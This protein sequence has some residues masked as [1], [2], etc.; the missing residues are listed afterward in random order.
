MNYLK[1][2]YKWIRNDINYLIISIVAIMFVTYTRT[3]IPLFYQ[4][5]IDKILADLKPETK[6][7]AILDHESSLPA[8]FKD[9]IN[10]GDS[11]LQKLLFLVILLLILQVIR[12]VFMF[13][14]GRSNA[15]FSESIAY[16]MRVKLYDHIQ[17]LSYSYHTH[18]ETGDLI[19]RSTSDIDT[20]RRFVGMQL[21]EVFRI[22]FLFTFTLIQMLRIHVAMTF[23]S[24]IVVPF[25]FTF[26]YIFFKRIQS[27][28]TE[29][30]E[31][32]GKMS[33]ALQENLTGIR[34]V[35]A[36]ANEK[37]EINKF[38]SLSRK[39][40]DNIQR[41]INSMAVY[42][43]SSDL[44]I[45]FQII[46][47]IVAG[48]YFT[49]NGML[50]LGNFVA[51]ISYITFI[52]WPIRQLGR[53]IVDFGKSS[54]SLNRIEE[55]LSEEDEYEHEA[56]NMKTPDIRGKVEFRNVS[57]QFD[58]ANEPTLKN[59]S[60]KINQGETIAVI[61]KTG[62][63]KSTLA[64]LL[65]RLYDYTSGSIKIDGT[66]L[67]EIDKKWARN[68]IGI[69]LQEPFLFSRSI[70]ENI[71]ILSDK[72]KM[73]EEE[74]YQAA[75]IASVHNDI[76]D[77]EEGYKTLV[78]ERGVTLS[79]GQKQRVA[80]ARML[81]KNIPILIFD[82][83]LSAVD[84]E[85]DLS[86]RNALKQR[87]DDLTKIIITHRIS[88]AMEADRIIV[89]EDGEI[90]EMGSHDELV[91]NSRIYKKIWEIQGSVQGDFNQ[92]FSKEEGED[93]DAK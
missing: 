37:H 50:S 1:S 29:T 92:S 28:F 93:N 46:T 62:S 69:I 59:V 2:I 63:G 89:L 3:F 38:D 17:N 74:I 12:A 58:D 76:L 60:F 57:F 52:L 9:F 13:I 80:I 85:T 66:E 25:I 88:T 15:V 18:A 26:A 4:Y 90:A 61:G 68:H 36:F 65:V 35:K 72:D 49:I 22:L 71:G 53:V 23:I 54:V 16:K 82:D 39:Y 27:V 34:V 14:R 91:N 32:E 86:I 8:L 6:A 75:Q 64:H 55:V 31:S 43:S 10:I 45:F 78:G 7:D 20:V 42:W 73:L 11:G 41:I 47:T 48:A 81:V 70:F 77:F 79:G 24:L 44:I 33:T 87:S 5:A 30:E 83:S 51:F 67:R 19:Q 84:T 21:P 56:N 40:S